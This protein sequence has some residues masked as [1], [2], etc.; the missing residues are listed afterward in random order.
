MKDAAVRTTVPGVPVDPWWVVCL[1]AD[2]CG[3]SREYRS[4]F[5]DVARR[6]PGVR[7]E[8]LDV[9]DREDLVDDVDVE[10]FPTLLIGQG[11]RAFFLGPLLP[12]H[13]VLERLVASFIDGAPATPHL[14]PEATPLLQRVTAALA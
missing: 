1:C 5:E 14:P 7:W 11:A 6:W 4:G 9:E 12:Q 8:W 10:T 13:A 3:V 2:W